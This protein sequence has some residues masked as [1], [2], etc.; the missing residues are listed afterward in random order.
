MLDFL[1]EFLLETLIP[2]RWTWPIFV[3]GLIL[4]IIGLIIAAV[5]NLS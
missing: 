1:L 4:I 3:T 5:L 2:A